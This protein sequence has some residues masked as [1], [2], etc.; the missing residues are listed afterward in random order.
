VPIP[1]LLLPLIIAAAA[2]PSNRRGRRH[3]DRADHPSPRWASIKDTAA[4]IGVTTRAIRLMVAD[5]RL[6]QY[7]LSPRIVRLNLDEVDKALISGQRG[8]RPQPPHLR[9]GR[10]SGEGEKRCSRCGEMKPADYFGPDRR[11]SDGLRSCCRQCET[12]DACRRHQER[13]R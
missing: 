5:G 6:T 9:R 12:D 10:R 3:P 8:P 2:A 1:L 4:Y 11:A 7:A 13:S